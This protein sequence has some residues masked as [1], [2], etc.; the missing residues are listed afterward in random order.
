MFSIVV[1]PPCLIVVMQIFEEELNVLVRVKTRANFFVKV[2]VQVKIKANFRV[3]I[4]AG[5]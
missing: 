1:C 2:P 4:Q 5:I 3:R